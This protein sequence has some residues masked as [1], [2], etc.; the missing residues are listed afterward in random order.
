[1][2][3]DK[4]ENTQGQSPISFLIEPTSGVPTYLQIVQQV[5]NALRVGLLKVGD[6]LPRVKDVVEISAINPNTVLKA[7]KDLEQKGLAAG[8]QG[9]GTFI[10]ASPH[11]AD[12]KDFIQL[13]KSFTQGW[14]KQARNQGLDNDSIMAI[15]QLALSEVP[16]QTAKSEAKGR[17]RA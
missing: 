5:E 11:S 3:I 9:I 4:V 14:L 13:K 12:L 8:K 7:Y 17:V 2:E 15:I 1:M 10:V 16:D 6:R